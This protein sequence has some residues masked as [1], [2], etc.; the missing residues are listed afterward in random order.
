MGRSYKLLFI[1]LALVAA[2]YFFGYLGG[3]PGVAGK[4][5]AAVALPE[6]EYK[7]VAWLSADQVALIRGPGVIG[8]RWRDRILLYTLSTNEWV[9]LLMPSKPGEC[10]SA[11]VSGPLAR[12]PDDNLG[13]I[14]ECNLEPI[15]SK[16]I[17]YMWHTALN[18]FQVVRVYPVP[19]AASDYAFT[20]DMSA[21]IQESAV[22]DGLENELYHVSQ[23]GNIEQL[24]AHYQRAKTPTLSPDGS[25]LGFFGTEVYP[26]GDSAQFQAWGQIEDLL[27]YPWDLYITQMDDYNPRI[28]VRGIGEPGIL[29][30]SPQTNLLAFTGIYRSKL[31]L[32]I[33]NNDASQFSRVW[34]DRVLFDWSPDGT[35][36][37][38][39]DDST[40]NNP[41]SAHL[42]VIELPQ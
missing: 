18:E 20:P 24:F 21:W 14:Y 22:G 11:W 26:G 38:L 28:V 31:G 34:S 32:W 40:Q 25:Q 2:W 16:Y 23:S 7:S 36:V 29:K 12:L 30:W 10:Y 8:E 19:F 4:H 37:I 27:R 5:R 39:V 9:E 3:W 41:Q 1:L 17:L 13:F 35:R 15:G 6:G 33:Y 42:R